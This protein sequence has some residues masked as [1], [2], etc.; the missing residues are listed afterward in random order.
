[1]EQTVNIFWVPH[2]AFS[3]SFSGIV[4]FVI[5]MFTIIENFVYH[6]LK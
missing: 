3:R 5:K 2:S 6:L 4:I 1:M